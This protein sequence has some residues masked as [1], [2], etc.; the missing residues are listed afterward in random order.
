MLTLSF[1]SKSSALQSTKFTIKL[2]SFLLIFIFTT[3]SNGFYSMVP[4][5]EYLQFFFSFIF[6]NQKSYFI[7]FKYKWQFGVNNIVGSF[8]KKHRALRKSFGC[9]LYMHP[10]SEVPP[11]WSFMNCSCC[12]WK[13]TNYV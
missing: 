10:N 7:T 9:T 5:T 11:C 12:L 4:I 3:D 2:C 1:K 8:F 13:T 6:L